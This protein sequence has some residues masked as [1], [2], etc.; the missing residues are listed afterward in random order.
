[1]LQNQGRELPDLPTLTQINSRK[2]NIKSKGEGYFFLK[3]VADMRDFATQHLV[4]IEDLP[5]ILRNKG[6]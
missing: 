4:E 6:M 1:M 3:T 5:D 2:Q